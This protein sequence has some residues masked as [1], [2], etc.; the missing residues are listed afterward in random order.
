VNSGARLTTEA[1]AQ[2]SASARQLNSQSQRLASEV[3]QLM[4]RLVA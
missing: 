3:E 4:G 1:A 2:V